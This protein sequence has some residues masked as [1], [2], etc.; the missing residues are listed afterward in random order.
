[1]CGIVCMWANQRR[2]TKIVKD[3]EDIVFVNNIYYTESTKRT[4]YYESLKSLNSVTEL[5]RFVKCWHTSN[6]LLLEYPGKLHPRRIPGNAGDLAHMS[7][8]QSMIKTWAHEPKMTSLNFAQV[9]SRQF[10]CRSKGLVWCHCSR[11]V[12]GLYHNSDWS[13]VSASGF[14]CLPAWEVLHWLSTG[15]R[16]F[17]YLSGIGL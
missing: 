12:I 6:C 11:M 17:A 9:P 3:C 7:M 13:S 5:R 4:M 15:E 8:G 10:V 14:A 2:A 1:M 16:Y